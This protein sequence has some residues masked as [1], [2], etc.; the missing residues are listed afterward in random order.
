MYIL[1]EEK[2]DEILEKILPKHE[3][4]SLSEMSELFAIEA[5]L[6]RRTE[7]FKLLDWESCCNEM[8]KEILRLKGPYYDRRSVINVF[9]TL[10]ALVNRVKNDLLYKVSIN[11]SDVLGNLPPNFLFFSASKKLRTIEDRKAYINLQIDYFAAK[12]QLTETNGS[13]LKAKHSS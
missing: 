3:I 13:A 8:S 12:L 11:F 2:L 5:F 1:N 7:E 4:M 10:K 9:I 6:L